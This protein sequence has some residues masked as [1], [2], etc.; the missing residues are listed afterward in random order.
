MLPSAK[1]FGTTQ[2]VVLQTILR[3]QIHLILMLGQR[4]LHILLDLSGTQHLLAVMLIIKC[5]ELHDITLY[6]TLCHH[7]TVAHQIHRNTSV[8]HQ[9]NTELCHDIILEWIIAD[10]LAQLLNLFDDLALFIIAH[11]KDEHIRMQSCVIVLIAICLLQ[12]PRYKTE[13]LIALR[14][15]VDIVNILKMLNV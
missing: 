4:L 8:I 12:Y 15:T 5:T 14:N 7:R 11:I 3:L 9:I 1:H 6:G 2:G 13:H 10:L